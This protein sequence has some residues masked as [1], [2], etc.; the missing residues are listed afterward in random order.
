MTGDTA[1]PTQCL[2]QENP[3]SEPN[4]C[5]HF[6]RRDADAVALGILRTLAYHVLKAPTSPFLGK[7]DTTSVTSKNMSDKVGTPENVM[8]YNRVQY[9]LLKNNTLKRVCFCSDFGT[10][11]IS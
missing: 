11:E 2:S 1:T 8:F 4:L 3:H 9:N 10:G 5:S 7:Q 6:R